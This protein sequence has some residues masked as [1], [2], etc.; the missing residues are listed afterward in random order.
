MID[1]ENKKEELIPIDQ[2]IEDMFSDGYIAWVAREYYY[3]NYASER[4][5][6]QMDKE[7]KIRTILGIVFVLSMPVC[8]ILKLLLEILR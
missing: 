4:E 8:I 7:N 2:V 3:S 1:N 5:R 6:L